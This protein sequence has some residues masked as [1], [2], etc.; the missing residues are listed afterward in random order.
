LQLSLKWSLAAAGLVLAI[1][2]IVPAYVWLQSEAIIERR[3]PLPSATAEASIETKSIARGA[4]LVAIAGC[5]DCHGANLEGRPLQGKS[6]LPLWSSNLRLLAHSMTDEEFE[7]AIR[8][9]IAS[10]ST[11]D[12]VMP[13]MDYTYMSEADVVA[14]ISYLR[15]L[16]ALGS[17]V[18]ETTFTLSARFAIADED[19]VPV[20]AL[21]PE[22]PSSLELG[23]RYD[24]GHY[25][26]RIAC[27]GCHGT[28][29]T[30]SRDA[31]DLTIVSRY[32]RSGFFAL[33]RAGRSPDGRRPKDMSR[34]RFH[35]LYDYEID[36]LYDYLAA[37]AQALVRPRSPKTRISSHP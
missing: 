8:A 36:A 33:L 13:S 37:R 17:P 6:V 21:V 2:A 5:S 35:A 26:A 20:A 32:S 10:D 19:M 14:I 24:G 9:G 27:A 7:R 29:L 16:K 25:L 11:S 28:D 1:S 4:H 3:Y 15:T 30:G 31:P 18:P 23:P 22:S 12:W 34:P